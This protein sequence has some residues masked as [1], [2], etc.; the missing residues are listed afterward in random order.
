MK[1]K[2]RLA[3]V[4]NQAG[5]STPA[6]GTEVK[7]GID[8][9]RTKWV[10]CVRW[11]GEERRRLTTPA[12]L[13]HV[14]ALV[15]E[16]TGCPVHLT[17]EACGFGYEIAWWAQEQNISVT[18]IAPSRVERAPGLQVKTDRIDVGKMARKLEQGELKSIYIP[19]RSEHEKRQVV[20]TYGQAIKERKRAQQRI[21]SLM[22]EHGRLGPPPG[23]G[24]NV[25]QQ[26]LD[27]QQLA[28]EVKLS[29]EALL[30]MR[31]SADLQAKILRARLRQIAVSDPYRKIIEAL[32]THPGVAELSAIRFVLEIGDIHR[33]STADSIGH[34]LGLTPSEYSS[35]ELV[36]RGP[37]LKC[38]PGTLR[39]A[40]L[41]CGWASIRK[42]G[43]PALVEM[44]ERLAARAG[45]KRA[46]VAVTRRLV[47]RLR[48][49]WLEALEEVAVA[50]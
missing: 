46:I 22:Q 35:G 4:G 40:M 12:E 6:S 14:Q 3:E 33:F 49:R 34:Y 48:A 44:F 25:Y 24:W 47:V 11:E 28:E 42:G 20:R 5:A 23:A 2:L 26:W 8:L 32:C 41:Q 36:R 17:F 43:E 9:S 30:A 29:V 7:I 16:Y 15:G 1:K 13:K 18:V 39:A 38:G 31:T 21:R 10:Y 37:I 50:A 19:S 45:R 27:G